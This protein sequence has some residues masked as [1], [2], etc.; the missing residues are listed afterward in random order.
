MAFPDNQSLIDDF[1]RGSYPAAMYAGK[2]A[3]IWDTVPILNGGGPWSI[4]QAG[5][6]APAGSGNEVVGMDVI[7][8]DYVVAVQFAGPP[9]AYFA[10]W[11][12]ARDSLGGT[13][14]PASGIHGYALVHGLSSPGT[15]DL[16]SYG[17]GPQ[18]L[19]GGVPGIAPQ[20][21][22]WLALRQVGDV[23]ETWA[24][25]APA[26]WTRIHQV[27]DSTWAQSGRI[28]MEGGN[29]SVALQQVVGGTIVPASPN[30]MRM[31]V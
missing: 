17:G 20:Q 12:A 7:G 31:L 13:H 1:I 2:G 18:F 23:V 30:R 22:D 15:L 11:A 21:G 25:I 26:G 9:G 14:F 24:K 28:C 4:P 29:D 8:P 3:A 10:L 27:A 16:R 19:A 5:V 6:A